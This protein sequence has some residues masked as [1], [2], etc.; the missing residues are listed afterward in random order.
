MVQ[1]RLPPLLQ[2][3]ISFPKKW[4]IAYTG[5]GC[6]N[7]DSLLP[8]PVIWNA[9]RYRS[10]QDN[11]TRFPKAAKIN[12]VSKFPIP[13]KIANTSARKS[14]LRNHVTRSEILIRSESTWHYFS[15]IFHHSP[16][17]KCEFFRRKSASA[18]PKRL[19]FHLTGSGFLKVIVIKPKGRIGH[20]ITKNIWHVGNG[21]F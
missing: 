8:S 2:V 11:D 10:K 6:L 4:G 16:M 13:K 12:T 3:P 18:I 9:K 5:S 1:S 19:K 15:L 21:Y 20:G 17:K 14:M 7:L